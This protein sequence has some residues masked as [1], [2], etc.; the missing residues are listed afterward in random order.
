ML[1]VK[2]CKS[3]RIFFGTWVINSVKIN[4]FMLSE[5]SLTKTD[6]IYIT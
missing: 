5:G 4:I 1:V 3:G 2:S 6:I